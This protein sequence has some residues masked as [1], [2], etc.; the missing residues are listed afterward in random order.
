MPI[1]PAYKFMSGEEHH[2]NCLRDDTVWFSSVDDLNDPY[3]GRVNLVHGGVSISDRLLALT[4]IYNQENQDIKQS[5]KEADKFRKKVGDEDFIR[6]VDANTQ[7]HF[8]GFLK[9][10]H[11]ER[12]VLSLSKA[13]QSLDDNLFPEPLSLM[14][15]WGHYANGFRGMCVEY[16]YHELCKSINELNGIGVTAREVNYVEDELPI[17][18]SKT[19]LTDI[20]EKNGDTSREILKA[21]CTK[22]RAWEYE[23][24]V[25]V[26]STLHGV[27]KRSEK[28]I[29][30]VFVSDQNQALLEGV[31]DILK[32]KTHKPELISVSLHKAKFGFYFETIEY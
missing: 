18:T 20:V 7:D 12:H 11:T 14:M 26:I 30:R 31:K 23:N 3:E 5:R 9:V 25:R 22:H 10:H 13:T 21:Y 28:S 2:L 8:E 15:M 6:H 24:E 32:T 16:D 17:I 27:N 4:H 19:I 1:Q 29:N